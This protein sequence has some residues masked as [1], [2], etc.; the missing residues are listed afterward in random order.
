MALDRIEPIVGPKREDLRTG[1]IVAMLHNIHSTKNQRITPN[2]A[3]LS[4]VVPVE[5]DPEE[6]RAKVRRAFLGDT[7]TG[8]A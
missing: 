1:Q 5:P 7:P 8:D 4:F 6:E 2:E 3:A